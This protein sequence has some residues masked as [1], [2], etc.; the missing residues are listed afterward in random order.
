M[1]DKDLVARIKA[2]LKGLVNI[3]YEKVALQTLWNIKLVILVK[4]EHVMK[5]THQQHSKVPTGIGNALGNKGAVGISFYFGSL[6][7][8]FI[9]GHLT[10][11]TE[12]CHR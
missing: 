3:E 6:S 10:S 11:G 9:C 12:K 5:I 8:G 1:N 2:T 4:P 7:L